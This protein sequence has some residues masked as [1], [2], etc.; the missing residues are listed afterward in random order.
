[1]DEVPEEYTG[2]VRG[3]MTQAFFVKKLDDESCEFLFFN[4]TNPQGWVPSYVV[5]QGQK[6]MGAMFYENVEKG[7][8]YFKENNIKF[9]DF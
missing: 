6:S 8:Q 2:N 3:D 5:N 7:I 9:T 1:M 4:H